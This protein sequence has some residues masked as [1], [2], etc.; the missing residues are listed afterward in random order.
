MQRRHAIATGTGDRQ[1]FSLG[2]SGTTC[3]NI[4]NARPR[5][6]CS[7]LLLQEPCHR[8]RRRLAAPRRLRIQAI[9]SQAARHLSSSPHRVELLNLGAR[10]RSTIVSSGN[11]APLL[12]LPRRR[13][14]RRRRRRCLVQHCGEPACFPR[15]PLPTPRRRPC[16]HEAALRPSRAAVLFP[17]FTPALRHGTGRHTM[18]RFVR[19]DGF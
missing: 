8:R 19:A 1:L 11:V 16:R 12:S 14:R 4:P 10:C 5:H 2:L 3:R 13:A 9:D 18:S 17:N 6:R 15:I 7:T